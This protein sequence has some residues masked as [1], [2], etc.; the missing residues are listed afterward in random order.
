MEKP[1]C[2]PHYTC[3]PTGIIRRM[4]WANER[5]RY[6]EMHSLIGLAQAQND[7]RAR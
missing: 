1:F 3:R 2:D 4:A 5:R 6:Y 7:P